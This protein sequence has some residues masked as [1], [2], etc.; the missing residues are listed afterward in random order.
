[1]SYLNGIDVSTYIPQTGTSLIYKDGGNS[2][3]Y[4]KSHGASESVELDANLLP[5]L[6]V[7]TDDVPCLVFTKDLTDALSKTVISTENV[8]IAASSKAPV[9]YLREVANRKVDKTDFLTAMHSTGEA[10]DAIES[11]LSVLGS[12]E[13]GSISAAISAA[14]SSAE[15]YAS[16]LDSAMDGRVDAIEAAI[17]GYTGEGAIAGAISSKVDIVDGS[18][19]VSDAEISKLGEYPA[20]ATVSSAIAEK[21]TAAQVSAAISAAVASVFKYNGTIDNVALLPS[22]D[23]VVGTVY[24]VNNEYVYTNDAKFVEGTVY[25]TVSDGEYSEATV[26]AGESV[27]ENTYYV[28]RELNAEYAWNGTKWETLGSI[29][30]LSAYFTAA[31]VTSAINA[32]S[33]AVESSAS[34]FASGLDSAMNA[35]VEVIEGAT[36][37]YTS[38]GAIANAISAAQSSAENYASGLDSAMDSRVDV[39]EAATEGYTTAGAIAAA[40]SA[41]ESAATDAASAAQS[42][43]EAYASGLDS[44]M[45]TRVSA[46]ESVTSGYSGSG[47]IA[48]AIAGT[49][50]SVTSAFQ[51]ADSALESTLT[52]LISA[53]TGNIAL[54]SAA[55]AAKADPVEVVV[56]GSGTDQEPQEVNLAQGK[57]Y[58]VKTPFTGSLPASAADGTYIKISVAVGGGLRRVVPALGDTISG[59]SNQCALGITGEG[60]PISGETYYFMKVGTDWVIL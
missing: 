7:E 9:A 29:V 47:A 34:A 1:M 10:I 32:S 27:P 45:D 22:E 20:Y 57:W 44:A 52:D 54:N 35:R 2:K 42:S 8:T 19:L 17:S 25:Y 11:T 37:G 49:S 51:S 56:L 3:Y 55:I 16:G 18:S 6:G 50:S 46:I 30:D 48:N 26:T 14:Q 40:I 39:L 12:P 15:S 13:G 41:A 28:R 60:L 23:V 31:Q 4:Y 21:Q 58:I 5:I 59:S 43:A 38:N 33:S 24:F 36:S 53:N